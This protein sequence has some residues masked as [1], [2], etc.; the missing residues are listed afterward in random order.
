M[1]RLLAS[2]VLAVSVV[3][4]VSAHDIPNA[5]VDRSIQA[6]IAPGRLTID[7]EVS[8][9]ELTLVQD[10]RGLISAL[11]EGDRRA[12]YDRYGQVTGPL[13]AKGFLVAVNGRPL[14]LRLLGFDLAVEEHPRYTFHFEATLSER[15]RL[16]IRDANYVA[17]EGTSRL[18]LKREPGLDVRTDDLPQ[19]VQQIPIRP[20]WQL[21]DAEERRTKGIE[22]EFGPTSQTVFAAS[23][24]TPAQQTAPRTASQ[25]ERSFEPSNRLAR[26]LDRAEAMPLAALWALAFV[27]GA[28]HAIQ[29]GHG[30]TL[31]AASAVGERGEGRGTRGVALAVVIT[32]AHMSS[33][34]A[35]AL[36]LWAT[37]TTRYADINRT[38]ARV[39][40][41][42]IAAIGLWRLGRHLAGFGE[43]AGD[44]LHAP[45]SLGT[46]GVLSLGLAGGLVPCWD[47]VV[48]IILAEAVGRLTLGLFLLLGFSFGMAA[49]LVLVGVVATR[50]RGL[51]VRTGES[52]VWERRLGLVSAAALTA[53]G[54]YLLAF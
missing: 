37:R 54:L 4:A 48:L 7:Y 27:M 12:L 10:L 32:V 29:P 14:E 43:H 33:V 28:A 3:S 25:P 20:V 40:G 36:V 46:R 34:L 5:R 21:T 47:A 26:L 44:E 35:I 42:T 11:P 16:S 41:F 52:G 8:L 6:A 53:I 2:V 18:A 15:G 30:K 38:L 24:S 17:S 49:V 22:V 1:R 50:L 45:A 9:A 39:A 19:D 23:A 51:A 13:N 31:V